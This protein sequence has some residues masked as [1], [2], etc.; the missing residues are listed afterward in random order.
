MEKYILYNDETKGDSTTERSDP[1]F[2]FVFL[3]K[4]VQHKLD[5]LLEKS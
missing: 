4:G 1:N 5:H 2:Y 3:N